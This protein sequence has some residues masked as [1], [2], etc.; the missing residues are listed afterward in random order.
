MHKLDLYCKIG[1]L[2]N[3]EEIIYGSVPR[4]IRFKSLY[5]FSHLYKVNPGPKLV[6]SPF[7][8]EPH[9]AA[10]LIT[11][12]L[13]AIA[14]ALFGIMGLG[15][16]IIYVPLLHWWGLNFA[17][18]AVPLGLLLSIVT[19]AG[20]A[21]TYLREGMVHTR[22]GF[23]TGMAAIVGSPFG[24]LALRIIPIGAVKIILSAVA[25]YV[26]LKAIRSGEPADQADRASYAL[27][28]GLTL[29]MGFLMGF[30]SALVGVGGG[31]LL[32]PVLL[33]RGYPTKEAVGTTSM[34]VAI[35]TTAGFLFHLPSAKFPL[36]A[37]VF[38]IVLVIIGAR[39][40]GLW[41]AKHANP[42]ALR[43]VIGILIMIIAIKVGGEGIL[44]MFMH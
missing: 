14:A 9:H 35:S 8:C 26:G 32:I 11:G 31:F 34:V 27:S 19:G 29:L 42:K 17:T 41:A 15:S 21:Y 7:N 10:M 1:G 43:I 38:F 24:V 40:G 2:G 23:T 20:V 5:S 18:G 13:I 16:G 6:F 30:F 39:M 3:F 25:L 4:E 36:K 44:A 33:A 37:A 22:T 28:R 12:L